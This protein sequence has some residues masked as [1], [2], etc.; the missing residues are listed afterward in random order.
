MVSGAEKCFHLTV[1][2]H[3]LS[4]LW[5]HGGNWYRFAVSRSLTHK[6]HSNLYQY[7]I[8][9]MAHERY[10]CNL[11]LVIFKLM[12]RIDILSLFCYKG[13]YHKTQDLTCDHSILFHIMSWYRQATSLYLSQ[14]WPWCLSPYK[15]APF[16]R[17]HFEMDFLQWKCMNIDWSFTEVCS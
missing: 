8:Y 12:S 14:C 6:Y 5:H 15:W 10:D 17:R 16:S 3:N 11:D 4:A 7:A 1:S 2:S 9:K 13:N